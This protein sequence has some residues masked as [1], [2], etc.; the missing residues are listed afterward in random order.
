MEDRVVR[1]FYWSCFAAAVACFTCLVVF[2]TV[3]APGFNVLKD[4]ARVEQLISPG[5]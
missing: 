3:S 1:A 2:I 5:L 4:R